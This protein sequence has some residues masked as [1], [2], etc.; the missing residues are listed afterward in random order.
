MIGT[1]VCGKVEPMRLQHE[2]ATLTK[3]NVFK[4][5][6]NFVLAVFLFYPIAHTPMIAD[7]LYI[8]FDQVDRGGTGFIDSLQF[9][10]FVGYHGPSFR[11]NGAIFGAIHTWVSLEL[12]S[13]LR[14]DMTYLFGLTKIILLFLIC[15]Q[16]TAVLSKTVSAPTYCPQLARLMIVITAITIQIHGIWSN[17]PVVSFPIAGLGSTLLG[18][19]VIAKF[20]NDFSSLNYYKAS[21]IG[22]IGVFAV[23]YYELTYGAVIGVSAAYILHRIFVE[24][25]ISR[26]AT[27]ITLLL[28]F[29]ASC[30]VI[31]GRLHA[32]AVAQSYGGTTVGSATQ[33]A[34]TFYINAVSSLP[35]S[36][37]GLSRTSLSGF[38]KLSYYSLVTLL[39]IS[40]VLLKK[41]DVNI[42]RGKQQMWITFFPIVC[43]F[44]FANLLLAAT[45][46]I[47][48]EV[49]AIGQVYTAYPVGMALCVMLVCLAIYASNC[50]TF[51]T[52]RPLLIATLIV[53]ASLQVCINHNLSG[54]LRSM[55]GPS[56]ELVNNYSTGSSTAERCLIIT[57]W[58]N[59][60]W[61]EYYETGIFKG[62]NLA[63]NHYYG[64]DYCDG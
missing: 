6:W 41:Q 12:A 18:L 61:P 54:R 55:A 63:S 62:L 36:G 1:T 46:K 57:N 26:Q 44:L 29:P 52:F 34:R 28:G 9:G 38:P 59:G 40:I 48:M 33:I 31:F 35:G 20:S 14:I 43:Y 10:W 50:I 24:R 25:R 53:F 51:R 2:L 3:T 21:I 5:V 49:R 11:P 58:M 15:Y 39:V 37:W 47:Q 8:P 27:F 64:R 60:N 45:T 23:C 56:R 22:L 32:S 16:L 17:D 13:K 4:N 19:T 7:D 30:A 42:V